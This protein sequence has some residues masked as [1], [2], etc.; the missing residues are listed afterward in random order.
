MAADNRCREDMKRQIIFRGKRLDNGEWVE[1]DLVHLGKGAI[2][3]TASTLGPDIPDDCDHALE[4]RSDEFAAV[5]L[6]TVGQWTGL[7]DC[8][9]KRIFEGDIIECISSDGT[10]ISHCIQF[11]AERGH[12][13]Q[14][15][16]DR[17]GLDDLHEAGPIWQGYI[18][19]FNKYVIGNVYDNPEKLK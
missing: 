2:I 13:S 17:G 10:P 8:K 7:S 6:R 14:Y 4:Y 19:E 12:L 18:D 3:I 9:G 1:G 5:D 16:I 11:N 15:I